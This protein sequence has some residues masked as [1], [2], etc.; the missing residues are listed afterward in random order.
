MRGSGVLA[1]KFREL[2][3][4]TPHDRPIALGWAFHRPSPGA[5]VAK[6]RL[7]LR[8]RPYARSARSALRGPAL[9][10]RDGYAHL[11]LL[12]ATDALRHAK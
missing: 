5:V 3:G 9:A 1:L 8:A 10:T 11:Y 12:A 4:I 6:V 7:E 2:V